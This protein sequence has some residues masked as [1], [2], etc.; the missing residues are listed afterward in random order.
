MKRIVFTL[1]LITLTGSA[2]AQ[3]E[4]SILKKVDKMIADRQYLS[5]YQLLD[6]FDP[7]NDR[8]AVVLK[9]ETIVLNYF[10][11]SIMHRVFSLKNL[12]EGENLDSVRVNFTEGQLFTFE[13][14]SLTRRLLAKHPG[15]KALLGGHTRFLEALLDDYSTDIWGMYLDS[16]CLEL[17][18]SDNENP[19]AGYQL[20]LY[21]T[22]SENYEEAAPY[23][24]RTVTQCD[25]H[26]RAHYNLGIAEYYL[27]AFNTATHHLRRAYQGYQR[28]S[29]KADAARTL[30]IIYGEN[31]NNADSAL[32]YLQKAVDIYPSYLNQVFLLQWHLDNKSP[33]IQQM[34]ANCW[35]AAMEDDEPFSAVQDLLSRCMEQNRRNDVL[36]LLKI[37]NAD[38]TDDFERGISSLFIGQIISDT[39]PADAIP[40]IELAITNFKKVEAPDNFLDS[41]RQMILELQQK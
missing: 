30:G 28:P 36:K 41:L 4:S 7:T 33:D 15:D 14:D 19:S 10:T 22:M 17:L 1:F 35:S 37:R 27:Q 23:F 39:A 9:K 13:A 12:A 18:M 26:Y 29:E 3:K 24:V 11:Q 32:L 38:T 2:F 25:T 21:Y 34:M 5:A 16:A 20:G 31:L 40:W 8:P 6:E